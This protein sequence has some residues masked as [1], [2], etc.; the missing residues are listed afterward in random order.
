MHLYFFPP[1]FSCFYRLAPPLHFRTCVSVHRRDRC[2]CT[3][4]NQGLLVAW[5]LHYRCTTKVQ[6]SPRILFIL[7]SCATLSSL[8]PSLSLRACVSVHRRDRCT[9]TPSPSLFRCLFLSP[10]FSLS[11]PLV[12][13]CLSI[14]V[15][16]A[17]V[18]PSPVFLFLP[19]L[20]LLVLAC[21]SIDVTGALVHLLFI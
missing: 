2:T 10:F 18:L 5:T 3:L 1:R 4:F 14:D 21:L 8:P 13:A 9:R 16:G 15:T 20:S 11:A 17:L 6:F 7:L 19:F 12:L